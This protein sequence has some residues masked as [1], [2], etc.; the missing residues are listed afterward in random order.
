MGQDGVRVDAD[1][2]RAVAG[3]F[4]RVAEMVERAV[5]PPLSFGSAVAG[6][7]HAADGAAIPRGIERVVTDAMLW[8]RAAAE[9]GAGLRAGAQRYADFDRGL[10]GRLGSDDRAL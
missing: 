1:A 5:R 3:E 10:A 7:D 6:R 9:I 8:S 2:L 4:E